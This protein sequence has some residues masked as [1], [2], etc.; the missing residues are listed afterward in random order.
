MLSKQNRDIRRN[1]RNLRKLKVRQYTAHMVKPNKYLTIFWDKK[2]S[3]KF[4]EMELNYI[5]LN[6]MQNVWSNQEY[7]DGL[8]FL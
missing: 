8:D 2:T 5:L 7:V 3:G 4:G 6:I 1:I